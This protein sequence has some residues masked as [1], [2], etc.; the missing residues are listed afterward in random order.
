M[1]PRQ[2]KSTLEKIHQKKLPLNFCMRLQ[3]LK[4]CRCA[5]LAGPKSRIGNGY[6]TH[7]LNA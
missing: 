6:L 3:K 2:P 7:T 1:W 5:L 4:A